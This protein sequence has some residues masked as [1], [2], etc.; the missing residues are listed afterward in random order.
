MIQKLI[1][2]GILKRGSATGY[3][4]KKFISRE[5]ETFLPFN[6]RSIYYPLSKMEK[7]GL[8]KKK[9]FTSKHMRKYSYSITKQGEREFLKMCRQALLTPR[10]PFME[11]DIVLYFST[12]LNKKD[13]LPLLRLRLRFL[14]KVKKWLL[15]RKEEYKFNSLE[16][17]FL[18]R[19]HY[20]LAKA[21]KKFLKEI[22]YKWRHN[23]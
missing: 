8:I 13:I 9:I 10:R 14:E 19:H 17:E 12:F 5:L 1:I 21:E 22:I 23:Q 18:L 6:S 15:A 20:E 4:I 16:L 2:L 7:E 3:E 11:L